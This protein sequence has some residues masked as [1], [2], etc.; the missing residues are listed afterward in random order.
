MTCKYGRPCEPTAISAPPTSTPPREKPGGRGTT[1]AKRLSAR[2]RARET[3]NCASSP[4]R[5]T[6]ATVEGDREGHCDS[7][8]AQPPS[9]DM[10]RCMSPN[11]Y[12]AIPAYAGWS[13]DARRSP[14]PWVGV[15]TRADP[16]LRRCECRR[17]TAGSTARICQICL[18]KA[19][20]SSG[21]KPSG[22]PMC[23]KRHAPKR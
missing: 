21:R 18:R 22:P 19:S 20:P 16:R 5:K 4:G 23:I 13:A 6:T 1:A 10:R 14:P 17:C 15:P 11:A 2:K 3:Y 9:A 7:R 8:T 12:L